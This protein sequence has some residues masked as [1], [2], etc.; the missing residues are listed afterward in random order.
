MLF[1]VT[2]LTSK[3]LKST[4]KREE[5]NEKKN[6]TPRFMTKLMLRFFSIKGALDFRYLHLIWINFTKDI[7]I[8]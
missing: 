2:S 1:L 3:L 7:L 8:D 5:G 6:P 4:A